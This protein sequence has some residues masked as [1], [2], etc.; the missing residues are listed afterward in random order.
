[1]NI[2]DV[3]KIDMHAHAKMHPN[4]APDLPG[5][6]PTILSEGQVTEIYDELNIEVGV[7]QP[8]VD[9]VG[10]ATLLPNEDNKIMAD[11]SNGRFKW[12]FNV[13]PY[14]CD[15]TSDSDLGYLFEHYLK[16]GAQ[17]VG[18][19][20]SNIYVDDPKMDN[21]FRFC[22]EYKLPVTIHMYSRFDGSYGLVDDLHLPRLDKMLKK[23]K[24]MKILGHSTVF[25]D[26][27]SGD[28]TDETR[29]RW[30]SGKVYEGGALTR[31]MRDNENLYCDLSGDSGSIAMM[32]DREHAARFLEEFADRIYYACDVCSLINT[33]QYKF[34][35]FLEDMVKDKYLTEENY[36]KIVR[37]NA[38]KLLGLEE[39]KL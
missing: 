36:I 6:Y 17:G 18:E 35:A 30:N 20:T 27:I 28:L 15:N 25:W 3:K 7:L 38:A 16:L 14:S 22:N 21:V 4:L 24:D 26:E 34:A 23:Y 10:G 5:L 32:R 31:L 19:V 1:M 9:M 39:Y 8:I 37:N 29:G 2:K 12:F 33:F 13:S 11:R